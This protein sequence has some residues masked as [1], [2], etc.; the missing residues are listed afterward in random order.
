MES[1]V[2]EIQGKGNNG[3]ARFFYDEEGE[4]QQ[5]DEDIRIGARVAARTQGHLHNRG[6]QME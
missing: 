3:K 5:E 1:S 4:E 2:W 6:G